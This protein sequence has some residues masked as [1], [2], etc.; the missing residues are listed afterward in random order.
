M[1]APVSEPA[2]LEPITYERVENAAGELVGWRVPDH[3]RHYWEHGSGYTCKPRQ[4]AENP[5]APAPKP[6]P[7]LIS[8]LE[9]W[10][11]LDDKLERDFRE[12]YEANPQRATQLAQRVQDGASAKRLHH[13][14]GFLAA[15]LRRL[16]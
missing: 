2:I 9:A 1:R 10:L 3:E 7:E 8:T 11:Y 12:L 16:T 13:P 14:G 15:E 5:E 4:S 6:L